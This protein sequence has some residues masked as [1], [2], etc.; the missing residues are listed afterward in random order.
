MYLYM[1]AIQLNLTFQ[2]PNL[3][4]YLIPKRLKAGLSLECVPEFWMFISQLHP[5]SQA[6]VFI[7]VVFFQ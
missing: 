1:I 5:P 3:R 4:D 2:I 7:F 6:T